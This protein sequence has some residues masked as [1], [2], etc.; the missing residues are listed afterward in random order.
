MKPISSHLTL[1]F[2][3]NHCSNSPTKPSTICNSYLQG[4]P[5]SWS[6]VQH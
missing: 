4:W 2:N 5:C 1:I 3:P 6:V